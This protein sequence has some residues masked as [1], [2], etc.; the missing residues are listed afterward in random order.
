MQLGWFESGL[1]QSNSAHYPGDFAVQ[2]RDPG[3]GRA[4]DVATAS[5]WAAI[6]ASGALMRTMTIN[7]DG[8]K[9]MKRPAMFRQDGFTLI[10]LAIVVMIVAILALIAYPSYQKSVRE[11]RRGDAKSDLVMISQAMER[12]FTTNSTYAPVAGCTGVTTGPG[13]IAANFAHSPLTGTPIN[14]NIAFT[15]N[16]L[17]WRTS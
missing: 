12:C 1:H 14:Y 10:E 3:R 11:G 4:T 9:A 6:L 2:H 16:T 13:L 5:L 8:M 15:V 7:R 17:N